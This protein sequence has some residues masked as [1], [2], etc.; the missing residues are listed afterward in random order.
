M[1]RL[2]MADGFYDFPSPEYN[3]LELSGE[4]DEKLVRLIEYGK[5][6]VIKYRFLLFS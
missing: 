4:F 2:S 1:T 3:K 6:S 5:I